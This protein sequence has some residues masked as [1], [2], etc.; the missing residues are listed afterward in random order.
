MSDDKDGIELIRR[1]KEGDKDALEILIANNFSILKGYVIKLTCDVEL[2]KDIIQD[3]LL[4]VVVNIKK[5]K[6][7]AKFSTWIIQIATNK[8]RDYLRKNKERDI[9]INLVL[10]SY[11]IEDEIINKE[12]VHEVLELLKAM[13]KEKRVVFILKHYYGYSYEEIS[14][15]VN[16]PVGTVRFR[17]HYGVK[18]IM[19]NFKGVKESEK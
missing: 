16:C 4:S 6:G 3:T 14:N 12:L 1:A 9:D 7:N 5:F 13:P 8:Y 2:S 11:S 15:I 10:D 17:L 19:K 18:E